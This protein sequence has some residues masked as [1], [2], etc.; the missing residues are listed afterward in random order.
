ML[1]QVQILAASED[2]YMNGDQLEFFRH[3][4]VEMAEDIRQH[5]ESAR[6]E[7][8]NMQ[9]EADELDKAALEEERRLQLR[10]LDR[11]SKLHPKVHEAI[12][13]IDTG[14]FGYCEV[15]GEPIGVARLIARPTAT[16][17]AEEKMRQERQ[18][19]N[20]RDL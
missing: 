1:T 12:K 5:I 4:L 15:T 9:Y 19:Q 18:E 6:S 3:I 14:D 2:D 8:Q 13:R 7:L 10:F 16:V 17:C 11:Q 20:Y